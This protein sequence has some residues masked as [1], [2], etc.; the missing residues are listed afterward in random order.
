VASRGKKVESLESRIVRLEEAIIYIKDTGVESRADRKDIIARLDGMSQSL[1]SAALAITNLSLEKCG[2]R[3][4]VLE[5]S[6]RAIVNRVK[7]LEEKTA[8]LPTV[9]DTVLFWRR[10]L[11]GGFSAAWK[12]AAL[13]LSSGLIGGSVVKF[14]PFH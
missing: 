10:V 13:I 14:W 2:A 6:F 7:D 3:L 11:G 4:D 12:I 1:N 8:D 9:A 5:E